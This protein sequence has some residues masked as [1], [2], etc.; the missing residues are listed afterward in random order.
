MRSS[1]AAALARP[2]WWALALAAF[3]VRGGLVV[4]LLPIISLPSSGRLTTM[5]APSVE[6]LILGHPSLDGVVLGTILLSLVV[7][8]LALAGAAGSWF[9]LALVQEA[10]ND[11]DLELGWAPR[12]RSPWLA[13]GIRVAAHLPT[14]VALGYAAVRIGFATY[15]ELLSP[16]DPSL[17]TAVRVLLRTPD[18]VILLVATWLLA[19]ALGGLATRRVAAGEPVG[20]ALRRSLFQLTGPRGLATLVITTLAVAAA[21][22]PFVFAAGNAWEHLRTYL[23]D[24]GDAISLFAALL[25]LVAT[26]VLGLAV[27]AA[28][29]AWRAVAWTV[30]V[31][32]IPRP[33]ALPAAAEPRAATG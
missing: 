26:W 11:D 21:A 5:L 31:A 19:E 1:L 7:G 8:S 32:P 17:P 24:G 16:G 23:L 14:F 18:A 10:A 33:A 29:L 30:L 25:L 4:A 20:G 13:L 28:A 15:D 22:V 3:L 9:E 27:L 6:G 12:R 2:D